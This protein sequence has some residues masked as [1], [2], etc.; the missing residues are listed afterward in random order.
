MSDPVRYDPEPER[1]DEGAEA[2]WNDLATLLV[3]GERVVAFAVQHRLHALLH[4]RN[5]AAATSG[6][7]IFM[8]RRLLGGYEPFSVRWQDLKDVS[9]DVGMF[10][11]T[12]TLAYSANLSDTAIGEG[13]TR[14]ITA[15]GLRIEP[16]QALYRECQAQDQAWREKRRIR[17]I[18]E[19]RAR[20]GGV[21]I[22]TGGYPQVGAERIVE[23][24]YPAS[25]PPGPVIHGPG[26]GGTGEDPARRL[27]RAREMLAQGLITDAEYEAI[28]A[29]IVGSL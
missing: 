16:A 3:T 5:L 27:A 29:R 1:V 22:A 17:A 12:V 19:M 26:A 2:A 6:R 18:E 21:Q 28:K 23:T 9:L 25:A 11:A 10:S 14:W 4:R 7:F 15:Q 13:E 24:P 20:A 8:R